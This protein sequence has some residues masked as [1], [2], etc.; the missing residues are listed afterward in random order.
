MPSLIGAALSGVPAERAG[1]AAGILTTM[2]QF[3]TAAGIAV[4]GVVFYSRLG[5][6]RADSVSAMV[7]AI[8][9]DAVI[10]LLATGLSFLLPRRAVPRRVTTAGEPTAELTSHVVH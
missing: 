6:S 3:G 9:V 10:V 8:A 1:A 5:P 4:I 2:Q 7:L